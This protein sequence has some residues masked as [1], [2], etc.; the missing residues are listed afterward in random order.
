MRRELPLRRAA[1]VLEAGV[2]CGVH[3]RSS[4]RGERAMTW[5]EGLR[6]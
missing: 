5:P 6:E 1:S 2:S 3:D 4:Q